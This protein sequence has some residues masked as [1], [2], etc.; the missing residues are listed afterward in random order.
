MEKKIKVLIVADTYHPKVDG[1]LKF[2]DEFIKR[3]SREFEISL[4]VPNYNN[5]QDS[6]N[7]SFLDVSKMVSLS[8]YAPIKLSFKNIRKIKNKIKEHELIFVQGPAL[9]SFLAIYYGRKYNK[10][11]VTYVHVILWE[12]YEKFFPQYMKKFSFSIFREITIKFYNYCDL[13]LVPYHDLRKQ[14]KERDVSSQIKIARLGVDINKFKVIKKKELVRKKLHLP[15]KK[16][17]IGYVGR[18]SVE[19]NVHTLMEAFKKLPN[20]E[21]LRLLIVGD[22][23]KELI[24]ELK[25]IKN[26][27]VTGFV[28]N[29]NEYLHSMDIFVMPSLTE[30]TSLATL[31]AMST[32]LPVIATKVGFMKNYIVKDYN[33]EFFPKENPNY[34][35]VKLQKLLDNP[36]LMEKLGTN[37]RKTMAYSF[38]WERSINRI[39]RILKEEF[40]N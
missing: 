34:L 38:S 25:E 17:I 12:L 33:G 36:E 13:V 2:M 30:T 32:G 14:L 10:K 1:T 31:E 27:H 28:D 18:V 16:I 7:K 19:K 9:T 29:V 20:Q 6:K 21:K 11:V 15:K 24:S 22:G 23:D 8:N 40:Y 39:K 26:C 3:S 37:A 4:L 5:Y 35:T